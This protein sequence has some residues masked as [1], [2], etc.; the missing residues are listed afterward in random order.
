MRWLAL[1]PQE[2]RGDEWSL[3]SVNATAESVTCPEGTVKKEAGREER[4][5][6]NKRQK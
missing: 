2:S 6:P 1:A 4:G 3:T 5:D